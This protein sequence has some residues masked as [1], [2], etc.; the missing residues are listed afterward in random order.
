MSISFKGYKA[1][2]ITLEA[3]EGLKVGSPVGFDANGKAVCA[4]ANAKFIGVCTAIR[5]DWA[6]IQT[7]GYVEVEYSGS[8]PTLG[9]TALVADSNS[10]VKAD[11]N[12]TYF[13]KV[14]S[15]DTTAKT[16]GFIL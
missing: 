9:I 5:D 13:Y 16:V 10:K 15:V 7:D 4:S 14:L 6:S 11:A 3:G 8:A 2:N 12:S 1:N